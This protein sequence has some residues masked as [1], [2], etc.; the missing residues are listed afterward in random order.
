MITRDNNSFLTT[1]SRS[2]TSQT[3]SRAMTV[4]TRTNMIKNQIIAFLMVSMIKIYKVKVRKS[5]EK[6]SLQIGRGP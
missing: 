2:M 5:F 3:P 1:W 6:R 4:K